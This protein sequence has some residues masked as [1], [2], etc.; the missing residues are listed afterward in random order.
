MTCSEQGS[1]QPENEDDS[2]AILRIPRVGDTEQRE[3][4]PMDTRVLWETEWG[5]GCRTLNSTF[6]VSKLY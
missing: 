5:R 1:L 4:M 2:D 6:M 3:R